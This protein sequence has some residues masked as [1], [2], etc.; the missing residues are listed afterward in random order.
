MK[1]AHTIGI[2]HGWDVYTNDG[3]HL[4]TAKTVTDTHVVVEKGR[5]FKHDLY[6]PMS[7]FMEADETEHRATLSVTSDQIDSMGWEQPDSSAG[8]SA[9]GDLPPVTDSSA[10]LRPQFPTEPGQVAIDEPEPAT[11]SSAR[12]RPQ[13]TTEPGQV[14][15]DEPE[16]A[17]PSMPTEPTAI[18]AP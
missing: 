18:D 1:A 9:A 8:G 2:Q 11:E 15:I 17:Q 13:L 10:R 6:I 3:E 12:L 4:G 14:A 16:A 7:S 5:I